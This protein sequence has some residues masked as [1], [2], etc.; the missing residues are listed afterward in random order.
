M[1]LGVARGVARVQALATKLFGR[2]GS[3]VLSRILSAIITF[4]LPLALVRLVD[5]T[6]YGTYKQFFLV[7]NTALLIGPMG[8]TQSLFYFLPRDKSGAGSYKHEDPLGLNLRAARSSNP[9]S[10]AVNGGGKPA[11]GP[12]HHA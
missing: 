6:G 2:S 10:R 8:M 12:L 7:A 4:G 11:K 9:G 1:G 3:L 5:P